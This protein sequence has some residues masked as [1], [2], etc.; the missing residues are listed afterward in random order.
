MKVHD[1]MTRNPRFVDSNQTIQEAARIMRDEDIGFLGI[2]DGNQDKLQGVVTDRDIVI[3]TIARG[4]NPAETPVSEAQSEKVLYCYADDA[5]EDA[6]QSLRD[7]Q[8]H[9]LVVLDNREDKQ[10]VGTMTLGD[11]V[12]HDK[13]ELAGEVLR[14]VLSAAQ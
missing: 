7:Q 12:R 5:L 14:G 4:L 8:I 11:V 3:R 13:P 2:R 6:C 9:R 1:V 10:L